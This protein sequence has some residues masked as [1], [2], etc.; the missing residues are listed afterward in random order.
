MASH[1][2][3]AASTMSALALRGGKH[4]HRLHSKAILE[5][6]SLRK[7]MIVSIL[8]LFMFMLQ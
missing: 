2:Y 7:D 3:L 5:N 4:P 1:L 6:P 8:L